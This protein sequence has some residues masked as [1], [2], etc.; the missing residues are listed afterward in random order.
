MRSAIATVISLTLAMALA[1]NATQGPVDPLPAS[2]NPFGSLA[3][4]RP[5]DQTM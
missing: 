1:V 3:S 2:C 4:Q 5:L